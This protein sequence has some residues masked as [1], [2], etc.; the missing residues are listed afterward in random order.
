MLRSLTAAVQDLLTKDDD[1]R[2]LNGIL[3]EAVKVDK[4]LGTSSDEEDIVD[5]KKLFDVQL[6]DGSRWL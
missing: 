1:A 5:L 3:D 6:E 2:I 4:A